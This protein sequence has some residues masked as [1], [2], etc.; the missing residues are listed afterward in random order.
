MRNWVWL[1]VLPTLLLVGC[2]QI[3]QRSDQPDKKQLVAIESPVVIQNKWRIDTGDGVAGRDVKLVLAQSGKTLYT[4]DTH[5]HVLA[6]NEQNGT[7]KWSVNLRTAI[8]AGPAVGEGKLVVGTTN[9]KVIAL[10]INNGKTAWISTT[11]SE[12][13]ATPRI[14]DDMVYVHTMDG[15]LSALSLVDGRLLWRFTHNLPPLILRRS[16][17]PVV[18]DD[19]VYAG[20]AN[21][22]LL[23]LRK[24][25]GS[26]AWAQDISHP[27]GTTDLQRMVDISADPLVQGDRVYAASYQGNIAALTTA[28]GHLLWERDIPSYAGFIADKNMLY[29][30]STNGDVVALEAQTGAT[31]WLQT[32]LQGRRLS[33]PTIM[34]K[35]LIIADD[36]GI[37]NVLEKA[38]GKFVGRFELDREGVEAAPIVNDNTVYILGCG[39]ELV[40]LEVS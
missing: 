32:D 34:G 38:S 20:F 2:T 13:L 9:G 14:A 35:Y 4:V 15:G 37:I 26:V 3:E 29:V 21:G 17:T 31:Y 19:Y 7:P 12:I 30:A 39:G 10:D 25:D 6:I 33:K 27:K 16:S 40:A 36:D 11:T 24:N 8:S 28:N 23:A 1:A 5:G 18:K 22:K